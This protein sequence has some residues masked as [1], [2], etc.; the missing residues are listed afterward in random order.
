LK[1]YYGDRFS[2]NMTRTPEGYLICHN[3]PISRTGEQDYL[4]R[5]INPSS[6]S[7]DLVPVHRKSADIFT[8]AAMASF[9]GKPVTDDHP[10]NNLDPSSYGAYMKGVV[11]NVRQGNGDNTDR[12]M[13]DLMI[14][15]P[16]LAAEIAAG[17]REISCGYNCDYIAN[18]DGSYDQKNIIG[19]HVAVVSQGRA[20]H[21]VSIKDSK[22]TPKKEKK[23]M[24]KENMLHKMFGVFAKD[25]E[26]DDILKAAKTI[27][28]CSEGKEPTHDDDAPADPIKAL[29]AQV[30]ALTEKVNALGAAKDADPDV[31]PTCGQKKPAADCH[32]HDD[33]PDKKDD[34]KEDALDSLEKELS[35]KDDDQE[36]EESVTV[37]AKQIDDA[38]PDKKDDEAKDDDPDTDRP[39]AD[40]GSSA[41]DGMTV[42]MIRALKPIVASMPKTQRRQAADALSKAMRDALGKP[43]AQKKQNAYDAILKRRKAADAAAETA[44][45]FG[46]NCLKM[47]PHYNKGGK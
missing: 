44:E 23:S 40:P 6:T 10:P 20:G 7:E 17:K 3:V 27:N 37:P 8:P 28:D 41:A 14:Y 46:K 32:T 26:P 15:D 35:A 16:N 45:S 29:A 47:N 43:A 38:D 11:Q 34:G 25:A 5:E 4:E 42:A 22:P 36:E 13:A 1:A 33:D 12:L 24:P 31:C 21:S 18:D 19:N 9:E 2:P 30:A 39:A